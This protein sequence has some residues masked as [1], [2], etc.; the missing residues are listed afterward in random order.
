MADII[1]TDVLTLDEI[2]TVIGQEKKAMVIYDVSTGAPNGLDVEV[3]INMDSSIAAEATARITADSEFYAKSIETIAHD[4]TAP[5]PDIPI[6]MTKT[7]EFITS[8]AVSWLNNQVVKQLDK[9]DVTRTGESAW[10]REYKVS[11]NYALH[12]ELIETFDT[13]VLSDGMN[14]AIEVSQLGINNSVNADRG[15][16]HRGQSVLIGKDVIGVK[17]NV[18]SVGE[19]SVIVASGVGTSNYSVVDTF[20]ISANRTGTQY[21]QFPKLVTLQDGEC[22]GFCAI[23]DTLVFKYG[24]GD[25]FGFYKWT[26]SAWD[27]EPSDLGISIMVKQVN[28]YIYTPAFGETFEGLNESVVAY[29]G[30]FLVESYQNTLR[31]K[32]IFGVELKLSSKGYFTVIVAS[33]V[34]TG[35]YAEIKKF[36]VYASTIGVKKYIFSEPIVLT[37]GQWI[38]IQAPED[39][40]KF[41]YTSGGG[42]F[43]FYVKQT[44]LSDWNVFAGDLGVDF[45]IDKRTHE[46]EIYYFEKQIKSGLRGKNLSILADSISTFQGFLASDEAG[47]DGAAY[48]YYYPNGDVTSVEH[49][50]WKMLADELGMNVLKNCSWSGSKCVGDSLATTT[51]LS[52]CSNRRISDLASGSINPDVIISFIGVNDWGQNSTLGVFDVNA[53]IPSE[54]IINDFISAYTIKVDKIMRTYPRARLF[55]CTLL[56]A[57]VNYYDVTNPGVYPSINQNGICLYDFNQAIKQICDALGAEIIDLTKCGFNFHNFTEYTNDKLHPNRAGMKMLKEYIKKNLINKFTIV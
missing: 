33:G 7:Y 10:V 40:S 14:A 9:V 18:A 6:G 48:A 5:T 29:A 24:T 54:G 1:T 34:G 52:G 46:E 26:G 19:L 47:Y 35:D 38:G 37:S 13:L 51:A 4:A 27:I 23:D 28:E 43:N 32:E 31:G 41:Y 3:L 21:I 12:T 20:K 30:Y 36:K 2:K 53:E 17:I 57:G 22:I 56:N 45:L 44:D 50:W 42:I 15:Y 8:G 39:T 55:C 16:Y 11:P 25:I 49:T